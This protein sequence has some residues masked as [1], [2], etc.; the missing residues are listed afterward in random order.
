MLWATGTPKSWVAF[1]ANVTV[2]GRP[3]PARPSGVCMRAVL[4]RGH[5]L[6]GWS[7]LLCLRKYI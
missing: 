4:G 3:C 2:R 1:D 5:P 6:Q 7:A